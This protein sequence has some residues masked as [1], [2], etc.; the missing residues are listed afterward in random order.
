MAYQANQLSFTNNY[1]LQVVGAPIVSASTTSGAAMAFGSS[2]FL[3][4]LYV[5]GPMNLSECDLALSVAMASAASSTGTYGSVARTPVVYSFSNA[6]KLVSF[7]SAS[8]SASFVGTNV[9]T[10]ALTNFSNIQPGWTQAGGVIVPMTFASS[11]LAPGDYV[12]GNLMSF[13]GSANATI[14]LMGNGYNATSAVSLATGSLALSIGTAPTAMTLGT[15]TLSVTSYGAGYTPVFMST[16]LSG[17]TISSSASTNTASTAVNLSLLSASI[18]ASSAGQQL[19][20]VINSSLSNILSSVSMKSIAVT[21]NTSTLAVTMNTSTVAVSLAT[22]TSLPAFN[23]LGSQVSSLSV[24][25]IFMNG[26]Y[27]TGGVPAAI[28]LTATVSLTTVGSVAF[29]QPWFALVGA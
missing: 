28:T 3:D 14:S 12:I 15:G 27:S 19:S 1:P 7:M 4:R 5:P 23:Y 18:T 29:A 17:L 9:T 22:N 21:L 25:G 24:P 26:V 8:W 10:G 20:L 13:S 2:L 6:T 11:E 16:N